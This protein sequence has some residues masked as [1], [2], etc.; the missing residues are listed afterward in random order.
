MD[1]LKTLNCEQ[2]MTTPLKPIEFCVDGMISSGLFILA[3]APKV[4]K[5]WLAIDIALSIAKGEKVLGRETKS[6]SALYLCLEDSYTRIQ[7]RLFELTSEPSE[8]LHFAIMAGTLGG[9]LE[10]QI[11]QFKSQHTD[12]KIIIIDTL[13]KIRSGDETSYASDYK[14]LS[15]LKNLADNLQIAILLIHHTRK[16]RDSDPF[17]MISGT[18]GISGCVDGSMVMI[19]KQRGGGEVVLHCVGR[20]IENLELHLKREGA[21]WISDEKIIPKPR[22][23]FSFMIH[24]FML[25]KKYFK[26]SATLLVHELKIHFDVEI[27]SNKITQNLVQHGIEL[28]SFGVTFEIK[29]SSGL[30]FIILKYARESDSSDGCSLWVEIAVTAVTP[31]VANA[32]PMRAD[33]SDGCC[34]SDGT[35]LK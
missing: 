23:T 16:C 20:D 35:A 6:G 29:R 34:E 13:Q 15:V 26:G 18:T 19:E 12:L 14:E 7:N 30:R 9:V 5:S 11:T 33:D 31:M 4:G 25:E 28:K 3:G 24:D 2:L 17:N 21:R 22:D 1:E 10:K 32:L 27:P 8:S